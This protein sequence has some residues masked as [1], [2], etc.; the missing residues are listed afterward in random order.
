M[1][2]FEV[3]RP[4]M[5]VENVQDSS[6]RFQVSADTATPFAVMPGDVHVPGFQNGPA[7]KN[8]VPIR[9]APMMP[10]AAEGRM[11][12][13]CGGE[14]LHLSFSRVAEREDFLECDDVGVKIGEYALDPFN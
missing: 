1:S 8:S 12:I 9:P 7:R 13:Q 3:A 14:C 10:G 2:S 5:D 4:H 11:E 6:R